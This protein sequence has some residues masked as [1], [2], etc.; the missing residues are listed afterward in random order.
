MYAYEPAVFLTAN[1]QTLLPAEYVVAA[2]FVES[3]AEVTE[4]RPSVLVVTNALVPSTTPSAI[5]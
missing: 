1:L 5:F 4:A 3:Q 2:I